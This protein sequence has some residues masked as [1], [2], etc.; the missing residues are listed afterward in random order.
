MKTCRICLTAKPLSAF[1]ARKGSPDG[2]VNRCRECVTERVRQ[3]RAANPT[4]AK[5]VNRNTYLANKAAYN[6]RAQAY[7][8]A[9]KQERLAAFKKNRLENLE[10]ERARKIWERQERGDQIRARRRAHYADNKA[11]YVAQARAREMRK[12]RAMP[13]WADEKVIE[14]I[15]AEAARLTSETGIVHHVDHV[16][17]LSGRNVCGLHVESNLAIITAKENLMKSNHFAVAA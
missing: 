6:A 15:Y 10:R 3:W 16:I 4:K 17:P 9:H 1:S 13:K 8:G 12:V 5:A 14:N 11:R 7:Y 2:L